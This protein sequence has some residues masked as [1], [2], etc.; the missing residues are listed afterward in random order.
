MEKCGFVQ[1]KNGVVWGGN[2]IALTGRGSALTG[3]G[4]VTLFGG[5][6]CWKWVVLVIFLFKNVIFDDN[7][8]FCVGAGVD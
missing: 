7:E 5:D 3:N 8:D 6:G 1:Q 2:G 4:T